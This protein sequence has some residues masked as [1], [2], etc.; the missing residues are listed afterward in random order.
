[1]SLVIEPQP[2]TNRI[3]FSIPRTV[4][5]KDMYEPFIPNF[6]FLLQLPSHRIIGTHYS[7]PSVEL[8]ATFMSE[9]PQARR[10]VATVYVPAFNHTPIGRK[11]RIV[12]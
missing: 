4:V 3:F 1:M 10:F 2:V 12:L 8:T 7:T 5:S 9:T 6:G 11:I